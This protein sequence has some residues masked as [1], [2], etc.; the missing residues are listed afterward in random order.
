MANKLSAFIVDNDENTREIIKNLIQ[1]ID[2]VEITDVFNNINDAYNEI[3]KEKPNFVFVSTINNSQD[4]FSLIEK[5]TLIN[6][7]IK[8]IVM[9]SSYDT[10]SVIKA[11][12]AGA[13]E[14]LPKPLIKEDFINTVNRLKEQFSGNES[15][16]NCKIIT[17][18]SNK[19]GIGKTSIATNLALEIANITKEK[20]AI[21]DMNF[22]LGDVATFLDIKPS[23]D[24]SYVVKNI[25]GTDSNFLESTLDRYKDT[26]LYVLADP[27]YMEQSK[28]ITPEQITKLFEELRKSFSYVIVDTS[29]VFDG[30]TIT[31]L[32]NTDFIMLV[33]IVNLPAIRNCQRCLD[34][35]ERLGYSKDKSKIVINRYMENDEVTVEDVENAL[36][37]K[38]YWK[39]PNNYFTIMSSINKGLPVEYINPSSNIAQ[40]FREL[41]TV[42]SDNIYKQKIAQKIERNPLINF[43]SLMG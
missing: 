18:F 28:D 31:V 7:K 17:T 2:N 35:F 3:L 30:K 12:R 19:G 11:M 14:F 26:S 15:N 39:I 6:N 36:N 22:Q 21:V 16:T 38:V 20:V 34:V 8:F 1:D 25:D 29:N 27:P 41:A 37:K 23:F 40:S 9:A 4:V 43:K 42:L 32:D 24:I 10:N 33:T 13:R 5:I